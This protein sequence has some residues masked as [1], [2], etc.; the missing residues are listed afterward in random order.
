MTGSDGCGSERSG[1]VS[2]ERMKVEKS[3]HAEEEY[4]TALMEV[5]Y[6][7]LYSND[8][9]LLSC[10]LWLRELRLETEATMVRESSFSVNW[11]EGSLCLPIMKNCL[12]EPF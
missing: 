11:M 5:E 3:R 10:V 12:V 9:D 7:F 4:D 6:L 8:D 2:S 1:G